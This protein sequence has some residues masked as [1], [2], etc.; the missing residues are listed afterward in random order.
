MFQTRRRL[1]NRST[2]SLLIDDDD[3]VLEGRYFSH[4]SIF[5]LSSEGG[6]M[7]ARSLTACLLACW[8]S[9]S[10]LVFS[11]S[12]KGLLAILGMDWQVLFVCGFRRGH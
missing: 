2:G 1:L 12:N 6:K 7:Y 10:V 8:L 3:D 9:G 4:L 11:P 5:S